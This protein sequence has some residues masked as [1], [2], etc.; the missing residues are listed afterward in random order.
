MVNQECEYP[1]M[2]DFRPMNNHK[3]NHENLY[4]H[5][6]KTIIFKLISR[7]S[8][9]ELNEAFFNKFGFAFY[10]RRLN[11][12]IQVLSKH[13]ITLTDNSRLTRKRLDNEVIL[14]LKS[15]IKQNLSSFQPYLKIVLV[16]GI[17]VTANDELLK[18]DWVLNSIKNK[19][20]V[21]LGNYPIYKL[22]AFHHSKEIIRGF[23][24]L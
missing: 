20:L 2:L 21:V 18:V 22:N 6:T 15:K 16:D 1:F 4:N 10:T 9:S 5:A 24:G 7:F 13:C 14:L 3:N 8:F 19:S 12:F 23:N 17:H 11:V